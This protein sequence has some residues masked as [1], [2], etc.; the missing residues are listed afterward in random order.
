MNGAAE[1]AI[2]VEAQVVINRSRD[3]VA[4]YA[5]NPDNDPVWISGIN[6]AKMLTE[7]PLGEGA[8][9][10]RLATFLGKRIEYVLEVVDHDPQ[11]LLDMRSVKGPFPLRVTYRFEEA[12][13]GTL[14]RIRVRG[15]AGGFYKL[16]GPLLAMSV[17]RSIT[18]DVEALKKIMES[19]AGR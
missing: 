11:A 17:K 7:P 9:V 12:D 19:E 5:M 16:A 13:G 10:V 1:M 18:K 6:A 8:Q 4:V 14:V 2:D 3:D 15:E